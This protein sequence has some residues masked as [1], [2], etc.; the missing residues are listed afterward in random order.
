MSVLINEV[1]KDNDKD[2]QV[3]ARK[4]ESLRAEDCLGRYVPETE[5]EPRGSNAGVE[6]DESKSS[7]ED[8]LRGRNK[9]DTEI[10]VQLGEFTLK[11]HRV[12]PIDE[13]ICD[14]ADFSSVF[15]DRVG[16]QSAEVNHTTHRRWIRLVGRR[17]DLQL[18]DAPPSAPSPPF[19]R[20]YP[21]QL[22]S[23]ERWVV[24]VLAGLLSKLND[25]P[26]ISIDLYVEDVPDA[27]RL[28]DGA[29]VRLGAVVTLPDGSASV[30]EIVLFRFTS[31]P[32]VHVY[33]IVQYGRRDYASLVYSTDAGRA[34]RQLVDTSLGAQ[35]VRA[36]LLRPVPRLPSLLIT[37]NLNVDMGRQMYVPDRLLYGVIPEALI[38][39]Y[40]FW[41]H[42]G[43][44]D[45]T[46]YQRRTRTRSGAAKDRSQLRIKL[47]KVKSSFADARIIRYPLAMQQEDKAVAT[48]LRPASQEEELLG[49]GANE[50][51]DA[52]GQAHVLVDMLRLGSAE[53]GRL[54]TLCDLLL[55]LDNLTHILVWAKCDSNGNVQ[56]H[57]EG[58]VDLIELPRLNLS[59]SAKPDP[60]AGHAM[61]FFCNDHAGFFISDTAASCT[62]TQALLRG[63]PHG[64]LLENASDRT[65]SILLPAIAKPC[66]KLHQGAGGFDAPELVLD[67]CD[68]AWLRNL[69][70]P[71]SR[72]LTHY[73]Y[74]I[75]SSRS[76]LFT[77]TLASA[78][79]LILLRLI[80]GNFDLAFRLADF[81]VADTQLSPDEEQLVQQ[82]FEIQRDDV[83][84][85]AVACRL[86]L[87]LVTSGTP[88][89]SILNWNPATEL[90]K[91]LNRLEHVSG[92][93]RLTKEEEILLLELQASD[94][95]GESFLPDSADLSLD[96]PVLVNRIN[97]LHKLDA[98]T[99]DQPFTVQVLSPQ[100]Q[101]PYAFDAVVDKSAL[102]L[103]DGMLKK[104]AVLSYSRPKDEDLQNIPALLKLD[105]W[106]RPGR[107]RL[108]GGKDELGFLFLYEL[109]TEQV[110]LRVLSSDSP[111]N[112]GALLLRLLPRKDTE[113][114]DALCSMLRI[115]A[116][117]RHL[118][119]VVPKFEDVRRFKISTIFRGQNVL[120]RLLQEFSAYA[121]KHKKKIHFPPPRGFRLYDPPMFVPCAAPKDL[122][123][124]GPLADRM[125]VAARI[126]DYACSERELHAV[127]LERLTISM[128]DLEALATCPVPF[129]ADYVAHHEAAAIPTTL[130]FTVQVD[131]HPNARSYVA[132]QMFS[133]LSEDVRHHANA[134]DTL[135][136]VG[137]KGFSSADLA[138]IG[139]SSWRAQCL[140]RIR[141]LQGRLRELLESDEA[142]TFSGTS[143]V[144]RLANQINPK[145]PPSGASAGVQEEYRKRIAVLFARSHGQESTIWFAL[146]IGTML[147]SKGFAELARINPF[148]TQDHIRTLE[149]AVAALMLRINRA[150]QISRC[151]AAC[152]AMA[153]LLAQAEDGPA[154]DLGGG[155]GLGLAEEMGLM[156]R[157]LAAQL[158]AQ[159][160]Y[161][162]I[163]RDMEGKTMRLR[164]DPRLLVFEFMQNI[165]LRKAQ[166][167]LIEQFKVAIA[168]GSSRCHQ[169]L[170]G[171]GKTT[172]VAPILALLLGDG[173][174]LVVQVVPREL[175]Q[176]SC[177]C[178]AYVLLRSAPET[179]LHLPL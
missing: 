159:R 9:L 49:I 137:L 128:S 146:L 151:L 4:W 101:A 174:R 26:E 37:R 47:T 56:A 175:F 88:M 142:F 96:T 29:A 21:A 133:R 114:A 25:L 81:C 36:H 106:T 35:G 55:R 178:H 16:L 8:F 12:Q 52:E 83:R 27:H 122:L 126:P 120:Q 166:V 40:I 72:S 165:V 11:K 66:A 45:L 2:G 84:T 76:F 167:E 90:A 116:A 141:D 129:N 150:G 111:Y 118:A 15:G 79:Y 173:Q 71:R 104:M 54:R 44:D 87:I 10:N 20:V 23:H 105:K 28:S 102:D 160:S 170:M 62:L 124:N 136:T 46:G 99:E 97:Y 63:I 164:Y 22:Q 41:Q 48:Q 57:S 70:D 171:A 162:T 109:M 145:P 152:T 3:K 6:A 149:D 98:A 53:K 95:S 127:Q 30:K 13:E 158:S 85:D 69:R 179:S 60:N 154:G 110:P 147:S 148:L 68:E 34:Y 1:Y 115:L 157:E 14:F 156:A 138:N 5:M 74:P 113:H 139:D 65:L 73:L 132:K 59:F 100:Q 39:E 94:E 64:V 172:V 89:S 121:S 67:R 58:V 93:C 103:N 33:D 51:V 143:A 24:S 91:Y 176:F 43:S 82:L 32:V 78:L 144:L 92:N 134:D 130:P 42:E 155:A 112:W 77:P 108:R 123:G 117:N 61:R 140:K 38:E 19:R 107:M 135:K 50:E 168:Q 18:W 163:E 17:H 131:R 75:H 86:K 153:E 31:P 119:P 169:M 177:S 161:I 125:L 80:S 7:Y